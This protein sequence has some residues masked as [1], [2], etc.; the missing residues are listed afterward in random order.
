MPRNERHVVPNP[1]GGWDVVKPGADRASAHH[2][3]QGAAELNFKEILE[4]AAELKQPWAFTSAIVAGDNLQTIILRNARTTRLS[5]VRKV[6]IRPTDVAGADFEIE[7]VR[8]VSEREHLA[9][10]PSGIGWQGMGEIYRESL[11][12]RSPETIEREVKLPAKPWLELHLGILEDAPITFQVAVDGETKLERTVTTP[13]RWEEASIDLSSYGGRNVKLSLSLK[14]EKD[15]AV[16]IW[17]TSVIRDR[18]G[19]HPPGR[20]KPRVDLTAGRVPQGVILV[21][22]DTTRRDHLNSYGY[23]RETAP[24]LARPGLRAVQGEVAV[25]CAR[26]SSPPI[27]AWRDRPGTAA[28]T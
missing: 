4:R 11:V 10:I 1:K 2:D 12:S 21:V 26:P 16:G 15:G 3:T 22:S 27:R 20:Q 18:S 8:L 9:K 24:T 13:D 19:D 17:G 25:R 7:S 28:P 5:T 23:K 14:G 6:L